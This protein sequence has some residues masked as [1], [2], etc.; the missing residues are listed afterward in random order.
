VSERTG[1]E[2]VPD[3]GS[4]GLLA[5]V[6]PRDVVDAAISRAGV[7]ELRDRALPARLMVY[8]VIG[9]WLWSTIGYVRVLK[10]VTAGLRWATQDGD[11]PALP[12]DGSVA[13]AKARLGEA[14]MADLF[15][16]CA[17]PV[18]RRGEPGVSSPGCGSRRWMAPC[19]TPSPRR[20]ISPRSLCPSARSCRR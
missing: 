4:I 5:Q 9:M 6:F 17:G 18:G 12:Y 15:A 3:K 1:G 2:Q 14:V 7:K 20:A 19:L 8:F 13:K 10:K 11:R 16:G